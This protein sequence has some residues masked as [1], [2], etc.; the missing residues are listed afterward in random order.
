MSSWIEEV[1]LRADHATWEDRF[2]RAVDVSGDLVVV[3]ATRDGVPSVDS[4]AA[5]VFQYDGTAWN[6]TGFARSSSCCS[7]WPD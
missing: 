2:G 7:R 4:R 5:Y 3:G 1:K 6:R